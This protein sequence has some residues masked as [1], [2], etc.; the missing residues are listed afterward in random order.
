MQVSD[1]NEFNVLSGTL[2][3]ILGHLPFIIWSAFVINQCITLVI[4]LVC[5]LVCSAG[6]TVQMPLVF[7]VI[8]ELTF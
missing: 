3:I 8:D 6:T 1:L 5:L 4:Q 7:Y 2:N